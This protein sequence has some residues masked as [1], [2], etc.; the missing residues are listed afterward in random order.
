MRPACDRGP[1]RRAGQERNSTTPV[2]KVNKTNGQSLQVALH[3]RPL[4]ILSEFRTGV[5]HRQLIP[6]PAPG[7]A[8]K[9]RSTHSCEDRSVSCYG[10]SS[11]PLRGRWCRQEQPAPDS[12]T[13]STRADLACSA[14]N[15][16]QRHRP[17]D[18]GGRKGRGKGHP[19][20]CP[21]VTPVTW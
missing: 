2:N 6:L 15:A 14:R 16:T 12:P 7:S 5:R 13:P 8:A 10:T 11:P 3:M 18:P 21:S 20:P 19:A 17:P 1:E 9:N 4:V